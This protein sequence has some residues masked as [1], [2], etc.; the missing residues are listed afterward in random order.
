[1]AA[2]GGPPVLHTLA[3]EEQ[4]I[5]ERLSNTG[6]KRTLSSADAELM[7]QLQAAAAAAD[8]AAGDLPDL[9]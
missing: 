3:E 2:D 8:A 9:V 7:R 1:M 4:L 5:E 6:R